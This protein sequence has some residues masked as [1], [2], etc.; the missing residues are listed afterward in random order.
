MDLAPLSARRAASLAGIDLA[1]A[2]DSLQKKGKV[3]RKDLAGIIDRLAKKISAL[4]ELSSRFQGTE[5]EQRMKKGIAG[6]LGRVIDG[7]VDESL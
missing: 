6:W 3:L 2:S 7:P 1:K 5:K 4:P